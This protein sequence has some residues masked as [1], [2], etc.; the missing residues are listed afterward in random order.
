MSTKYKMNNPEGI[1]FLSTA[2]V[3]WID[4]FTRKDYCEIVLDSL[5]YCAREKGLLIYAYVIMPSHV[6]LIIGRKENG[7][8]LSAIIRDFKKFTS[9]RIIKAIHEHPQESRRDWM[10][11]MMERAGKKNSNN[12]RF[13]FWQQD[14]HPIELEGDWL[15]QKLE[16][17]H[18]NP[19]EA[20]I[21][22][23]PEDYLYSSASSYADKGGL[24][25]VI[26]I[27][28]GVEI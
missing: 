2:V 12:T 5:S 11:W 13:Q 17:V 10:L 26:S 15:D 27:Y 28:D 22:R 6:H 3:Y 7:S 16:Y 20:G 24:L 4:V 25:K 9:A 14:N 19:V 18:N 23:K 8:E 1:Y 21:V